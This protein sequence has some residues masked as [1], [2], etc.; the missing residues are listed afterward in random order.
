MRGC[1]DTTLLMQHQEKLKKKQTI[2]N[3]KIFHLMKHLLTALLC[4]LLAATQAR[5][6]KPYWAT[7][8]DGKVKVTMAETDGK[9]YYSV[10]YDGATV[11]ERIDAGLLLAGGKTMAIDA[12]KLK[13]VKTTKDAKGAYNTLTAQWPQ[14]RVVFRL[15]DMGVAYRVETECSDSLIIADEIAQFRLAGDYKAYEALANSRDSKAT[16]FQKQAMCSFENTYTHDNLSR[17]NSQHLGLAPMLIE[18]D[19]GKKMLLGE[20]N[21]LDYPGAFVVPTGG[22]TVKFWFPRVVKTEHQGG[23]NMLQRVATEW[24]PYIAKVAGKRALPWRMML[25]SRND[26]DLLTQTVTRD[27]AQKPTGD[28]SWVKPGKVAWD[29]WNAW[30]L[31]GVNFKTG[32]NNET[33][34]YYIDFAA[35]NGIEYVILD[36]GWAVN[37]KADLFQVV[38]EIDLPALC[39]YARQ[40][41]VGLVLWAGY[42]AFDRDME[43]VCKTYSEMGIKGFK[44]DFMDRNDQQ[45]MRFLQRAATTAARYHLFLDFHGAPVPNGFTL[46]YPNVLN[47]EA[48]A[49][50]EQVKWSTL[51]QFDE[52]RHET[53]LPFIRQVVGPLDYTQGAMRN[54]TRS[55]YRPVYSEPMSQGTRCRQLALYVIFDSPFNMLCDAPTAYEA[56]PE[57]TRFIA[58]IPVTW[59]ERRVLEAKV[60]ECVIEACRKGRGQDHDA[61]LRRHQLRQERQR[62]C[63]AHG[64]EGACAAQAAPGPRRRLCRSGRVTPPRPAILHSQQ[65]LNQEEK[66]PT[67]CQPLDS[68]SSHLGLRCAARQPRHKP[69][70]ATRSSTVS[71]TRPSPSGA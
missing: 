33:Y 62:L 47:F 20:Y 56:N 13:G 59:D 61:V 7:S 29:W 45:M 64:H 10:D 1:C 25:L 38:P 36:E 60:G 5:A 35:R 51:K 2:N 66:K 39:N 50:L 23:H 3:I 8:P 57:C 14:C 46:T 70:C 54:A 52:V 6:M 26:G 71:T 34:K 21:V 16:S 15:Y 24:Q 43:Q 42:V 19:G 9:V 32:V 55:N 11:V 41:G 53:L 68:P 67:T 44:V 18:L 69:R 4:L 12:R 28:Y 30:N 48:V 65:R 37:K 27:L 17:L 22:T 49:G 63:D 58:G 40:K 31:K